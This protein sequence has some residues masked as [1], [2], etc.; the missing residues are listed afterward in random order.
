M[1]AAVAMVLLGGV[2]GAATA[3]GFN[4]DFEGFAHGQIID[5]EYSSEEYSFV[6]IAAD[7]FNNDVDLA[8]AFDTGEPQTDPDFL[9]L[10][11]PF[12]QGPF[13]YSPGNILVIQRGGWCNGFKCMRPD[14][15]GRTLAGP[16]VG[17]FVFDFAQPV[18]IHSIDFFDLDESEAGS[19]I[20]FFDADNN[21]LFAGLFVTPATSE[22]EG[23]VN[24][25]D[26]MTFDVDGVK[27]IELTMGGS[28]G[29]DNIQGS[30]NARIPVPAVAWLF[31]SGLIAG[32]AW[33]RRRSSPAAD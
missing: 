29:I 28:G 19:P 3:A 13:A 5:N 24:S 23:S 26:R 17:E 10:V 22:L 16:Y 20:R 8:V 14:D 21:E 1:R 11:A 7:N 9:D 2:S 12:E 27:R 33:I 18:S 31:P 32:I 4:L 30:M 6:T 15:E 25:W